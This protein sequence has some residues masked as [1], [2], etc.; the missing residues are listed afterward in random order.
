MQSCR[1]RRL[2]RLQHLWAHPSDELQATVSRTAADLVPATDLQSGTPLEDTVEELLRAEQDTTACTP[3][4]E[5]CKSDQQLRESGY[6]SRPK[7][8]PRERRRRWQNMVTRIVK[9]PCRSGPR[10]LQKP[11]AHSW[12]WRRK[13]HSG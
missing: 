8:G 12:W 2:R 11:C 4:L 6:S 13:K 1:E 9:Q 3:G 7:G 5:A 10:S